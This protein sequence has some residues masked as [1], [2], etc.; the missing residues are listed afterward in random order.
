MCGQY[1]EWVAGTMDIPAQG[2]PFG[3]GEG[4]ARGGSGALPDRQTDRQTDS[5]LPLCPHKPNKTSK[6]DISVKVRV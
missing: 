2:M 3:M 6:M 5:S 4:L 1:N